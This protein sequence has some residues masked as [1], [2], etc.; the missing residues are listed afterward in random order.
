MKFLRKM[1]STLTTS[2]FVVLLLLF[3]T[4]IA[5]AACSNRV[6]MSFETFGGTKISS[7]SVDAGRQISLPDDPEKDGFVFLG[8]Y[9][10]RDCEGE[11]QSLPDVMPSSSVTYYAKYA[12]YPRLTLLTEGGTLEKSQFYVEEG[13]NLKE[14]LKDV[15]PKK[16]GLVFDGWN[17]GDVP[18]DDFAEMGPDDLS[19]TARY[20]AKYTVE[21]KKQS[22][23]GIDFTSE[24]TYGFGKEGE[25]VTFTPPEYAHFLFSEEQS[26]PPSRV[27]SAGENS[28]V[29]TYLREKRSVHY[30]SGDSAAV[31]ETPDT[32]T[33]YL[34][35]FLLPDCGFTMDGCVFLGWAQSPTA[36]EFYNAGETYTI[37]EED[38]TLY[39]VWATA[40]ENGR[41][42]GG[43]LLLANNCDENGIKTALLLLDSGTG[44]GSYDVEK[45]KLN[46]LG[47]TGRIEHGA[48]L[49]SDSGA[50]VGYSLSDGVSH[51]RYGTLTLDFDSGTAQWE[52]D[53]KALSGTYDYEYDESEQRFSG[54]YLFR[55]EEEQFLFVLRSGDGTFLRQGEE[56]GVYKAYNDFSEQK[57]G[58]ELVLDGFGKAVCKTDQNEIEY[59]YS[60]TG[61]SRE[62]YIKGSNVTQKVLLRTQIR[63]VGDSILSKK[64]VF[65]AYDEERA[66]TFSGQD[67]ATLRLDGYGVEAEYLSGGA[68]VVG[69]YGGEGEIVLLQNLKFVLREDSFALA[70]AEAGYYR[71]ETGTLFLDGSGSAE[72]GGKRGTYTALKTGDWQLSWNGELI[73]F[74]TDGETYAVF[75]ERL[76]GVY[77]TLGGGLDLDG[78][79]GGTFVTVTDGA[80][81]VRVIEEND[82][83][84]VFGDFPTLTG[85]LSFTVDRVN[86]TIER[87]SAQE[88]G[89]Y[90]LVGATSADGIRLDGNGNATVY[91]D[92]TIVATGTYSYEGGRGAFV[93]ALDQEFPLYYFRF[94]LQDGVCSVYSEENAGVFSG[95]NCV[96]VLDGYGSGN[97]RAGGETASGVISR[98][99]DRITLTGEN[100]IDR[101]MLSGGTIL[102]Y[103]RFVRYETA[104]GA[105]FYLSGEKAYFGGGETGTA[106]ALGG[107]EY[108]FTCGETSRILL[109]EQG[110]CY[111]LDETLAGSYLT[112]EGD[113]L[114]LDGYGRGTLGQERCLVVC[115]EGDCLTVR[116]GNETLYMV[117]NGNTVSVG[118]VETLLQ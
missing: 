77:L 72:L 106:V 118:E 46:V 47:T 10:D 4:V 21:I 35:E 80:T 65:L 34:G 76:Y 68:S 59:D 48:F 73:R 54:R 63:Q 99:G 70:G 42:A 78:Y 84:E 85:S 114:I 56:A 103:E 107:G 116:I 104:D 41:G 23:N 75:D 17:K 69:A 16:D 58:G 15:V 2:L 14:F 44:T 82:Q 18:L 45:N 96:L 53:E 88:A 25:T 98:T 32:Q 13:T 57:L 8:W 79:G 112:D 95:E 97:V 64:P 3:L 37:G 36:T 110:M 1:C 19:L 5:A 102:F 40:Y 39:A 101:F 31:G 28:F 20:L 30:Q 29:F 66:G 115:R 91:S 83:F 27:L 50:Y 117:Q 60:G 7:I 86:G 67:G 74:Q 22:A 51:V 100:F 62:W 81:S 11:K 55:T 93:L 33:V 61:D 49:L 52:R 92:R 105:G 108:R 109:L 94:R 9:L 6:T 24:V 87:I 12:Q 113:L 89:S 43:T 38:E 71:G 111:S 26:L 90:S